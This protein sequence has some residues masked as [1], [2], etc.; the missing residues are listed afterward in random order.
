M[1]GLPVL[2]PSHHGSLS[3]VSATFVNSVSRRIMLYA[4]RLVSGFVAGAPP[5]EP[6]SGLRPH[7]LP[8]APGCSEA[9]S[10]P[11]AKTF[12]PGSEPGGI[13]IARLVLPQAEGKAQA[14]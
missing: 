7:S 5:Q 2:R 12:Q 6:A 10:S 3:A 14:R 8:S 11:T 9:M 13:S 4:L 1:T